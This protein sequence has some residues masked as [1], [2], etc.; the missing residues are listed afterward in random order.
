MVAKGGDVGVKGLVLL[1]GL[2][3]SHRL[4]GKSPAKP[5]RTRTRAERIVSDGVATAAPLVTLESRGCERR[6][7]LNGSIAFLFH[8][9]VRCDTKLGT[10]SS[11]WCWGPVLEKGGLL[12]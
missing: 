3:A 11:C 6:T 8:G 1:H 5:S 4:R 10:K 9:M 2:A 12:H 7:V